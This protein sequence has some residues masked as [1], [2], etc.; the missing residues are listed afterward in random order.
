MRTVLGATVTLMGG[1]AL[2]ACGG[3]G[4]S[5][6][7]AE[8]TVVVTTNILGDV[9]QTLVGDGAHVE[10]LMP[11]GS[12]PHD[13][14]PSAKQAVAMRA[15]DLLVVN[16]GGFEAG[17]V[18]TIESAEA[19]G[20]AVLV[21]TDALEA[22][23]RV[24]GDEGTDDHGLGTDGHEP[25]SSVGQTDPHFFTDPVLMHG[26]VEQLADGLAERLD[27]LDTPEFRQRVDDYLGQLD[28][29][30]AD[31]TATLDPL[32]KERR[33]LVT[34]HDELGSFAARFHF[35]VLGVIIPGG[36]TLA[37]PSA[38]A[39]ADLADDIEAAAVP[40]I[41]AETSS[42]A[43]LAEA[44]AAE[45]ADVEVVEI[46]A[47][48]LGGPDSGASTYLDMVRTNAERIAAALG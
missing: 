13:F 35:D 5:A 41:F 32:P 17:L 38:A 27:D 15:A 10:V 42:P 9:V 18:D 7:A 37:E 22:P 2:A 36:S 31:V 12:N 43:R 6:G 4:S 48:S 39:L 29:L 26:V 3:D 30:T 19:D 40:A 14:A 16:G 33:L 20:V 45:G 21:A 25:E 47:E 34:N 28:Q 23:A 24:G 46:Y 8:A 44:L 11:P 1:F